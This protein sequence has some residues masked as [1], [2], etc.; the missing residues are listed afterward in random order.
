MKKLFIAVMVM[1]LTFTTIP[2]FAQ[3]EQKVQEQI[4][5]SKGQ[6]SEIC[7]STCQKTYHNRE[8]LI[9]D[10]IKNTCEDDL[11]NIPKQEGYTSSDIDKLKK[12][13]EQLKAEM[14]KL[15]VENEKNRIIEKQ[16]E[17]KIIQ[18]KTKER[19]KK[20]AKMKEKKVKKEAKKETNSKE[21][22]YQLNYR[23]GR[24]GTMAVKGYQC[25]PADDIVVPVECRDTP[26]SDRGL[27]D[28]VKSVY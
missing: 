1:I 20:I 13:N 12:E 7:E 4:N 9:E 15:K 10:C 25:D 8:L 24:C 11:N 14:E 5:G 16:K 6:Y 21:S 19:Q 26:E 3:S 17:K 27:R 2:A 23:Y 22:C 18:L 28:G